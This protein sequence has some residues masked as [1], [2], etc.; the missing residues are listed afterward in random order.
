M[1]ILG[2]LLGKWLGIP[3]IGRYPFSGMRRMLLQHEDR[4]QHKLFIKALQMGFGLMTE[5]RVATRT[6]REQAIAF[7]IHPEKIR[8]PGRTADAIRRRLKSLDFE[9]RL[10]RKAAGRQ[11]ERLGC[12]II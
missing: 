1:G 2:T 8:M 4:T 10:G 5:I 9:R 6:T 12:G 11:P 7:G 3:V